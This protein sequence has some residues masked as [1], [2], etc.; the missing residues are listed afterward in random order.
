MKALDRVALELP[1]TRTANID[2]Q[3]VSTQCDP[4]SLY[5]QLSRSQL[6][7]MIKCTH[8]PRGRSATMRLPD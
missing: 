8:L 5:V 4:Y 6:N 2:G 1:G 3:A 7:P